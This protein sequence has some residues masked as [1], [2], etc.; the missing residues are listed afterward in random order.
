MSNMIPT[1]PPAK[2]YQRTL[3]KHARPVRADSSSE[4]RCTGHPSSICP[5]HSPMEYADSMARHATDSV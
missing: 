1:L 5:R 4:A 3:P 2:P